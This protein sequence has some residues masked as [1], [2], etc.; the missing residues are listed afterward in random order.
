[1]HEKG[2]IKYARSI[3]N[4][5]AQQALDELATLPESPERASFEDLITFI[6]ERKK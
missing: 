5:Y 4:D 6:I 2:G 1:V 3:M